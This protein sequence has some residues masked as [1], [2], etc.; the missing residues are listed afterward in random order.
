MAAVLV[1]ALRGAAATSPVL[2]PG[3]TPSDCDSVLKVGLVSCRARAAESHL[4]VSITEAQISDYLSQ[5][6]KPPREAVRAMLD[7][8][9]ANIAAWIRK[10]RQ[11]ISVATYVASR[12]TEIQ[13]SL[14][15]GGPHNMPPTTTELASM[16][17]MRVTVFL[18]DFNES[19]LRALR[20]VQKFVLLYPSIDGRLV[21][22]APDNLG[23]LSRVAFDTFL[24]LSVVSSG[25]IGPE[26]PA[27]RLED[28]RSGLSRWLPGTEVTPEFIRDQ[29]VAL[30]AEAGRRVLPSN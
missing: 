11:L 15:A 13:S 19:S 17:Q 21:R 27:I 22:V 1:V 7:P 10:Q 30:R 20:S 9:D 16:F 8:T 14:D 2:V 26:L 3:V 4:T 23:T 28:L 24:P 5:Y 6:G 18:S 12:M 25:Y 29:I